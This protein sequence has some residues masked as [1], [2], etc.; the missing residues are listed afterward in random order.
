MAAPTV[1]HH[2]K[3]HLVIIV[4]ATFGIAASGDA[5]TMLDDQQ[6]IFLA[7]VH[8]GDPAESSLRYE[9]DIALHK[10][11]TDVAL[12]ASVYP[13]NLLVKM[14][15]AAISVGVHRKIIRAFGDRYWLKNQTG[16]Q[17]SSAE[18][19]DSMPI[20]YEKAYGGKY[21]DPDSNKLSFEQRNP[22]GKGFFDWSSS[23]RPENLA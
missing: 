7:D 22:F 18:P 16:Y 23:A 10:S 20:A 19:F 17:M 12:I 14:A 3:N 4:K 8:W 9:S 21:L 15:R 6:E 5:L 11:S 13:E 2:D 1:C